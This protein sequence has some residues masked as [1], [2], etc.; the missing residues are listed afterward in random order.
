M[1]YETYIGPFVSGRVILLFE[2]LKM[3]YPPK[4]RLL[5]DSCRGPI[6]F[7]YVLFWVSKTLEAFQFTDGFLPKKKPEKALFDGTGW[8]GWTDGTG[9]TVIKSVL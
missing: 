3:F 9:W 5:A 6:V 2:I 7:T 8:T 1:G 4:G